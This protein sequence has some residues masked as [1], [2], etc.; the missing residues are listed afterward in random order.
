MKTAIIILATLLVAQLMYQ[1]YG[2]NNLLA[3]TLQSLLNAASTLLHSM[4]SWLKGIA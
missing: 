2:P 3:S 4:G 1:E